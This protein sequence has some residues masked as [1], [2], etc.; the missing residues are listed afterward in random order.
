MIEIQ[1]VFETPVTG[2]EILI[3]AL[4][5]EGVT[6]IFGIPGGAISP[7]YNLFSE[8]DITHYLMRHEQAAAHAADGFY[9]ASGNIAV[10]MATSGPG[11]LNLAT[12]IG[13]AFKDRSAL[14]AITGQTLLSKM[15]TDSFQEV[16][17]TSV[18]DSITKSTTM[19]KTPRLVEYTIKKMIKISLSSPPGPV[20]IDL[21]RD[22]QTGA[23]HWLPSFDQ[24]TFPSSLH[25]SYEAVQKVARLLSMSRLPV[26]VVGGG[27]VRS[28]VC[29]DVYALC[30]LLNCPVVTTLMGKSGFPEYDPLFCGMIGCNGSKYA[31]T[32]LQQADCVLGL[33]T[34]FSDRTV[35]NLTEFAP[36]AD[37]VCI[38]VESE[39]GTALENARILQG[40]LRE[41]VPLLVKLLQDTPIETDWLE[42]AAEPIYLDFKGPPF[43]PIAVLK[44][45]RTVFPQQTFFVTDTGQHQV[46][47]ANYL[48]VS[49]PSTFITSGGLG[50]MGFGV[51]ASLG[52]KVAHPE[53]P[54]VTIAGDGG[55]LMVCQEL[56]TS[57]SNDI[58][59]V[60]CIFN[61]GYLGMI[62]QSQLSCFNRISQVDL[63][64]SPDFTKLAE[65]FGAQGIRIERLEELLD[66]D[67]M[68]EKSIVCDI[69]V[70]P[71]VCV[72]SHSYSW[73]GK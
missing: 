49:E 54:V 64:P 14:L 18:F 62:R 15:G 50:C 5:E 39:L 26:I 7:V 66:I 47:C 10:A 21:P 73:A 36:K 16:E 61:N 33:G 35:W 20:H 65:V 13:T 71:T 41:V 3:D 11:C 4:V 29:R 70:D 51:P 58:P 32:L 67:V 28:Q 37:I 60:I 8:S 31:N 19:I 42:T 44:T 23:T 34:R 25:T 17:A 43:N 59:V 48:P 24:R 2:A 9:R 45:L 38:N 40:D 27:V 6:T 57:I 72:P 52:V 69:P 46:F 55:F 68:P 30:H 63:S 1:K 22:V 53:T 56:A 12:G